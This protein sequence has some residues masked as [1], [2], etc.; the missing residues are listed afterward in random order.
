MRRSASVLWPFLVLL[1]AACGVPAG[2][3]D[4]STSGAAAE[5]SD[6]GSSSR[7]LDRCVGDDAGGAVGYEE[8][9]YF[10]SLDTWEEYADLVVTAQ[11]VSEQEG[12]VSVLPDETEISRD[13]TLSVEDVLLGDTSRRGTEFSL[14]S[15]EPWILVDGERVALVGPGC[16][17]LEVG[18][19][20]VAGL[21]GD[22]READNSA[23]LTSDSV[24][25]VAPDG[26]VYDT[27]RVNPAVQQLESLTEEQLLIAI[28]TA[29]TD[30]E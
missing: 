30:A 21:L 9:H 23:L 22:G 18:D 19:R 26:H 1:T 3:D 14:R 5:A 20:I 11:V 16:V 2:V 25:V 7:E 15:H 13:L 8:V 6:A 10:E 17:R 12:P 4:V 27:D 29:F 28:R 24:F